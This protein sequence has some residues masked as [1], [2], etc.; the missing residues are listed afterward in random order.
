MRKGVG[1][2]NVEKGAAEIERG[3]AAEV[4]RVASYRR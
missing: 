1:E 2:G 4:E 3:V